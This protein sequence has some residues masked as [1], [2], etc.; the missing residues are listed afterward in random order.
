MIPACAHFSIEFRANAKF[1]LTQAI[2]VGLWFYVCM[3]V[4]ENGVCMYVC[5]YVCM[6]ACMYVCM[7]H[8]TV[9]IPADKGD[10][11]L[12]VLYVCVNV[13]VC[14]CIC[15]FVYVRFGLCMSSC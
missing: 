11:S 9:R 1:L 10:C 5:M 12:S 3:H 13:C 4:F 15:V 14:V 6:H 2:V 8:H 7:S